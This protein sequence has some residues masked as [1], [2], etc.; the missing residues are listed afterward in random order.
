[1]TTLQANTNPVV[2]HGGGGI[3]LRGR[4]STGTGKRVATEGRMNT[5]EYSN[6]LE[7]HLFQNA[8][9]LRLREQ[10][11]FQRDQ[12]KQHWEKSPNVLERPDINPTEH[13]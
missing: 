3:V 10:F 6:V 9:K 11:T 7:E 8:R 4:F 5:A 13:L 1:M 12:P 2:K